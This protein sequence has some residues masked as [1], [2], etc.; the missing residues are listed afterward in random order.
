MNCSSGQI[1][2]LGCRSL[3]AVVIRLSDNDPADHPCVFMREAI[4]VV[5]ARDGQ[6]DLETVA[7][8]Q[9]VTIPG[10]RPCG[11]ALRPV[12]QG[13][14]IAGRDVA[15]AGIKVDDAQR[16]ACRDRKG[17]TSKRAMP[18]VAADGLRYMV[19]SVDA[20]DPFVR[21]RL[22]DAAASEPFPG[23]ADFLRP[24]RAGFSRKDL[25]PVVHLWCQKCFA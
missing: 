14:V 20:R 1:P 2:H 8:H 13:G 9:E 4:E 10:R 22:L 12:E 23:F 15:V 11:N 25:R 5:N 24:F 17:M 3:P 16:R 6:Q 19:V 21:S 7:G 18:K